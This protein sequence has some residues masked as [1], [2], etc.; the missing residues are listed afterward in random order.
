MNNLVSF[1]WEC[2]L[3]SFFRGPLRRT[4]PNVGSTCPLTPTIPILGI[5]LE[6]ENHTKIPSAA[7]SIPGEMGYTVCIVPLRTFEKTF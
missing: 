6:R 5:T 3:V 7:L 4:Y 1:W 2:K